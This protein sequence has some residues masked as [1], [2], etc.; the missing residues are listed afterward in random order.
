MI[1]KTGDELHQLV[2]NALLAAGADEP[3]AED[4]AEHLVLANLS[5]V[6]T[7]GIWHL[8]RYV[9]SAKSG[10]IVATAHPEILNETAT[11]AQVTGNWT[12]G[13]V[14]AKYAIEV[15]IAKAKENDI[16]VVGLVQADHIGRLGHYVEMAASER[17]IAMVW[18]GGYSEEE[19]A[20]V[21]YGGSKTVL[22]TNPLAMGFPSGNATANDVRFCNSSSF[23]C[24][25]SQRPAQ[26]GGVTTQLHCRQRWKS[27]HG[28][29]RFRRW[30]RACPI[31]RTQRLCLDDG[32]R[33][34]WTN[35][36]RS[37]YLRRSQT[38]RPDYAAPRRN[39]YCFQSG[40]VPTLLRLCRSRR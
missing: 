30:R 5:G 38:R 16:A 19:P 21:P 24:Q 9:E 25:S 6:D 34:P 37:G 31:W 20:T 14:A 10:E 13:Q 26:R 7:H 22:H 29:E 32:N 18:A 12:F 11:S 17:L 23:R 3:N 28:C 27:Q 40:F 35:L 2:K 4:V 39:F 36:H 15:A 1:I 8:P 33:V